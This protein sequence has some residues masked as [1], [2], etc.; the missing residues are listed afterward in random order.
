MAFSNAFA[1][2]HSVAVRQKSMQDSGGY[3]ST[4]IHSIPFVKICIVLVLTTSL[5]TRALALY[6]VNTTMHHRLS[7]ITVG[8]IGSLFALGGNVWTL[9]SFVRTGYRSWQSLHSTC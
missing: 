5:C 2:I 9:A 6:H 4:N 3:S 8:S 7:D 1:L